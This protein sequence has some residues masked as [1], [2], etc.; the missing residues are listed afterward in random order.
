MIREE[1]LSYFSLE[2]ELHISLSKY[3][4]DIRINTDYDKVPFD[5]KTIANAGNGV[6]YVVVEYKMEKQHDYNVE[7]SY[8]VNM[9]D[10]GRY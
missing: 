1:I 3:I 9:D 7:V 5:I 10:L 2:R 6:L 8:S 4:N